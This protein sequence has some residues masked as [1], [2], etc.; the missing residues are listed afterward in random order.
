[1]IK[2][3]MVVVMMMMMEYNSLPLSPIPYL[4]H[5]QSISPQNNKNKTNI[6]IYFKTIN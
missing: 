2:I 3:M 1:M 6:V 4:L 5:V